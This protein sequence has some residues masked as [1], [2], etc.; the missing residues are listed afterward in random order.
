MTAQ[1]TFAWHQPVMVEAV[2]NFLNLRPGAVI[3]DGTV[4]TGGHSLAILPRLLP[5]GKLVVVDRDREALALVRQRLAEFEPQV[6]YVSDNYRNLPVILERLGLSHVDGVLLDVG[7]SSMQVD[8]PGRGF[9]FSKEGPLDMRMDPGQALTAEA[10]VN[11][12]PIDELAW[13]LESFGEERFAHRIAQRIVQERRRH[14]LTT[15]TQLANLVAQSVPPRARYGR[16]HPATRT[17]QALRI[18]VNDELG[19]LQEVLSVFPN[20]LSPGGRAV[21]LT[22]HSLEDRLVKRTFAEGAQHGFWTV[23]T[24]KP[25]RPTSDEITQNPRARSSKLRAVERRN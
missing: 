22:Y 25:L 21:L 15:T 9:S 1:P 8:H 12:R 24:K 4:G 10:L 17:F 6:T 5:H 3:V 20:V 19:A 14:P 16:L 2:L 13:M 7:M 23:L 11:E 18:A